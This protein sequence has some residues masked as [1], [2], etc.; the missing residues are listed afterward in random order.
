MWGANSRSWVFA[1]AIVG[2][3]ICVVAAVVAVPTAASAAPDEPWPYVWPVQAPITDPFR[4]P[5]SPYGPGNRGIEFATVPGQEVVAAG[6]GT[7]T[8]AGQVGGRLFVTVLHPDG[9]RTSYSFLRSIA[10]ARGQLV[11]RGQ[12]VGSAAA[13]FHVGAR[14]RDAYIDPAVLFGGAPS[15]P[16]LIARSGALRPAGQVLFDRRPRTALF[17]LGRA[18]ATALMRVVAEPVQSRTGTNSGA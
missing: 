12:K 8:F 10:V 1:K 17:E 4:A 7:V 3:A 6:A 9:V 2:V 5:A 16:R 14:I 15:S 11:G 18:G 13:V